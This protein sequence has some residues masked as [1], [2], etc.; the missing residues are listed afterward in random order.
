MRRSRFS[1]AL[2]L[3]LVFASGILVGVVGNRLY[4]TNT[5]TANNTPAPR[6]MAQYRAQFLGEMKQKVGANDE[7]LAKINSIMDDTK[8]RFDELHSKEKPLRDQ[9]D[10]DRIESIRALLDDKQRGAYDQWRADRAKA[11]A[12]KQQ[13]T[14]NK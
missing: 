6:T 13:P 1:A 3:A 12:A 5:V 8:R 14:R 7:Q 2:Y 10:H 11:A 4:M 9:I